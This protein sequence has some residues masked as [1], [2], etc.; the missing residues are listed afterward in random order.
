MLKPCDGL[1]FDLCPGL[2]HAQSTLMIHIHF[3]YYYC[4]PSVRFNLHSL[5]LGYAS[6]IMFVCL[7]ECTYVSWLVVYTIKT[8]ASH[9]WDYM[10]YPTLEQ[11]H[12]CQVT[13]GCVG[14]YTIPEWVLHSKKSSSS[15]FVLLIKVWNNTWIWRHV[16]YGRRLAYG[17]V[18][19]EGPNC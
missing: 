12:H 8:C 3:L 4:Y 1:L 14:M 19:N 11:C 17:R 15:L 16:E 7:C 5:P 9:A 6:V 18:V 10:L 2:P 13:P